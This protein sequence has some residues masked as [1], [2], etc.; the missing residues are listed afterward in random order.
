M[1][2]FVV[3]NPLPLDLILPVNVVIEP[4]AVAPAFNQ[5]LIVGP[6]AVIPSVGAN[7]RSRFY[8]S[9][10]GMLAGGF[11]TSM[12]EYTAAALYFGAGATNL[13]VGRQDLTA[14][15]AVSIGTGSPVNYVAGDIVTVTQAGAQ[16]G[17]VE[18]LTVMGAECRRPSPSSLVRKG[19]ATALRITCPPRVGA[20]RAG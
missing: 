16:A 20:G 7:S 15:A 8:T 13:W 18:I 17:Q 4:T 11:T 5:A 3:P 12:P 19:L 14:I 1:G 6:S 2:T 10:L 9:L